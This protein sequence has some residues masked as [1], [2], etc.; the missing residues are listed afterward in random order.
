MS[1]IKSIRDSLDGHPLYKPIR[2][3]VPKF[4]RF[5]RITEDQVEKIMR[6]IPSKCCELDVM[7]PKIMKQIIPSIITP[8]TNLINNSLENG[9]FANNWKMA[10]IKPLLKKAGLDLICKNYRPVSNLSFLSKILKK[11][12]LLQFNNHCTANNLL[13]DYQSAYREHFLCETAL[14]KLMDDILWNM[15]E[16]KIAAVVAID[17][18]AA[19]DTVDHD[20]LLD[21]LN[22]RFG[23]EGNTQ[24]WIDSYLRPRKFK[25]NI[26][27]SYSEEIDVKFSVPQGSIFGPVLYSTYASTL[28]EVI[29]NVNRSSNIS[30]QLGISGERLYNKKETIINLHGFADDHIMKKSFSITE[31]NSNELSTVSDLEECTS[32]VKEWMNHN[33]LKMNGEKMEFI[34]YGSRQQLKKSITNNI[35]V[36]GEVVD[37]TNCIKYLGAWLDDTLSLKHHITQKCKTAMWNLQRLKAIFPFLTTEACHT[38]VRGIVCAHVD[39]A[40][41][42]FAGLPDCE[43][44]KL[45]R[46]QNIV[47]KPVLNRTWYDSPEQARH[48]LHWLPIKARIQHKDLSLTY[49]SLNAMAPQYLQDLITLCPVARPGLRSQQSF[50]QLVIPFTRRKTFANRAFSSMAPRWW[51]KLP[52]DIKKTQDIHCFKAKLK[53]H[54]FK[55]YYK[56]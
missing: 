53:T 42:V 28:E 30:D 50:Q 41:A 19:F 8:I 27:Q 31:N 47:A 34:L 2:R 48:E 3:E 10:I 56:C 37:R 9:V 24:N 45:Q 16:Q 21:V 32:K 17:L 13:P 5:S 54:L 26:G 11:C 49:K 18:S 46:V 7:P 51:N 35:N 36:T 39:Y 6:S 22:N 29:N 23:L 15:E 14:V 12:A 33:R 25:V 38:V 44:S 40:N 52:T 4:S 1:K 20:V 55:E 43:I